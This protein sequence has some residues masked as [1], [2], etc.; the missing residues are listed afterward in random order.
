MFDPVMNEHLRR[1]TSNNQRH[2]HYL[3]KIVQNELI[4]IMAS[5]ICKEILF[6]VKKARYFSIILDCT[7]DVSHTEQMTVVIRFV[8]IHSSTEVTCKSRNESDCNHIEV[9]EHFLGFIPLQESTGASMTEKIIEHLNSMSLSV[10]N[11]RGQGYDNG[12]NMRG[13]NSGVQKRI[14]DINPR[15]FYIPCCSHTLNLVVNDAASCCLQVTTFFD[16]VQRTYVL[17]SASTRRWDVLL[18]HVPSLT[19]KP[20][21]DTRWSSRIDALIPLRYQLSCIC[22]ALD[23]ISEDPSLTG[24][25][26]IKAK[27]EALGLLKQI[28]EFK[29]VVAL[30][31]WHN[32]LFQIN[33]AS[34][35]LQEK[36]LPIER[37]VNQLKRT[38]DYL[39]GARSDLEFNRTLVDARELAEE[40]GIEPVFEKE[41]V[42]VR[43]LR[44]KKR[45]FDSESR[46]EL[47]ADPLDSFKINFYYPLLD[48]AVNV[49]KERFSQLNEVSGMFGFLY[50][51]HDLKNKSSSEIKLLCH[52]LG[53]ALKSK[54]EEGQCDV[55]A[56]E[57]CSELSGISQHLNENLPPQKLLN[58][59][60][61]HNL[62]NG[63]P[64]LCVALRIL[65][66]LPLS[67]ASAERSFSKLK[68]IKTYLR[69]TMC[70]ER[71]TGLAM[72]S[73]E[74]E[75]ASRID[76]K[77]LVKEFAKAKARKVPLG[78]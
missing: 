11:I 73:I 14:L 30:V 31:T 54:E 74:S 61:H 22:D 51:I 1:V 24:S 19:L 43:R 38:E 6:S 63:F 23:E 9:K 68:L 25:S 47:V 49:V 64:N 4:Q 20:L 41:K 69:S 55:D 10:E 12:S 27:A 39:S 18:R 78:F 40:A 37:A 35:I 59:I 8:Q 58:Y 70:Q 77:D 13:K 50:N 36:D 56:L 76:A 57:L 44:R 15:A 29:F 72:I 71:L 62:E 16:I 32:V 65:L 28:S 34:K 5:A 67:V 33:L 53:N 75:L 21:S 45:M 66:T 52:K 26:G 7:P 48:T 42:Y 46:D 17:F 3:G 2:P 60:Y